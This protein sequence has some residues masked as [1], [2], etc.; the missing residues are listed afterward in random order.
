MTH[1]LDGIG[2]HQSLRAHWEFWFFHKKRKMLIYF[3]NYAYV[4][5][6]NCNIHAH[7]GNLIFLRK[8][9]KFGVLFQ[10]CQG[11][12]SG[13]VDFKVQIWGEQV[14]DGWKSRY[15]WFLSANLAKMRHGARKDHYFDTLKPLL[16]SIFW[17]MY[18]FFYFLCAK[19]KLPICSC[20]VV[21]ADTVQLLCHL[22]SCTLL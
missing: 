5:G 2:P 11:K 7:I 13:I 8:N 16:I 21:R 3:P 9:E 17:K 15:R 10:I 14:V 19:I 4:D 22:F 6:F 18:W 1:Q 12:F 20:R